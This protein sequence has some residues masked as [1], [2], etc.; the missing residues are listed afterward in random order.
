MQAGTGKSLTGLENGSWAEKA[1]VDWLR[2]L[3][4]VALG[5]A[6]VRV[7]RF[8][9]RLVSGGKF[10]SFEPMAEIRADPDILLGESGS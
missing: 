8:L 4:M 9:G 6:D 3:R 5:Y 10:P 1:G 7:T 2:F